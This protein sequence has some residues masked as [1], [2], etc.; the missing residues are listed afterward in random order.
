MPFD[1]GFAAVLKPILFLLAL[2]A[3]LPLTGCAPTI[4]AQDMSQAM[5]GGTFN[6][7]GD[8]VIS[9]NDQIAVKVYGQDALSGTYVVSP[10]GVLTFP[11]AGFVPAA[12]QTSFQL[13]ERL[14][15]ALRPY[16]RNPAV[17]VSVVGRDSYQVYFSGEFQK[18]G[19]V[20]LAARTT[21][22]Q[23]I[24]LAGGLTKGASGRIVLLRQDASGVVRRYAT[25]YYN[26]LSGKDQTD[27]LTLERGDVLHAE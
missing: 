22:V 1:V 12:G 7:V 4:P 8:Y 11:L 20:V 14:T 26:I 17:T 27:R 21:L 23:G 10:S 13:T 2:A 19:A 5:A 6:R 15:K 18:P 24:A 3:A 9:A 25:S 16:V